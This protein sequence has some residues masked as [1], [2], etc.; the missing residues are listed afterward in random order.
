M[1]RLADNLKTR[2]RLLRAALFKRYVHGDI[3]QM[4]NEYG[5]HYL[6]LPG[7]L[8]PI[9]FVRGIAPG[10]LP[11]ESPDWRSL[12]SDEAGFTPEGFP[13]KFN[14]E[15]SV[16]KFLGELVCAM[17]ATAVIELGC[18]V[19]W[20]T[21]HMARAMEIRGSGHI[22]AVDACRQYLDAMSA[23]LAR[24]G[25]AGRATAVCGFSTDDTVVR[26][27]P[28][29]ADLVFLDTGHQYPATLEEIKLYRGRLA[30]GGLMVLHD[31]TS[32]PGVRR[33][34]LEVRGFRKLT[35]ATERSNG[36]TVLMRG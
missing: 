20:T 14:S 28:D 33:S 19:G 12:K 13:G 18:F 9:A 3:V 35:F 21:A 11:R 17:R 16:A 24:H 1:R 8:D 22:Y 5:V 25:L 34:L 36:L 23:N 10:G 31:S 26:A 15:P 2:W 6:D 32:A 30:D 4:A 27:L 7:D 29:K